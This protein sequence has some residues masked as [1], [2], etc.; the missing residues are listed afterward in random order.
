[1]FYDNDGYLPNFITAA[2]CWRSQQ[3]HILSTMLFI[4][5]EPHNFAGKTNW[6][7]HS[8]EFCRR[9]VIIFIPTP[10]P[11]VREI[12]AV[13]TQHPKVNIGLWDLI[14]AL[15]LYFCVTYLFYFSIVLLLL[16]NLLIINQCTNNIR[17]NE[18]SLDEQ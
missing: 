6:R 5:R 2:A 3:L 4:Q 7:W 13:K 10:S 17:P 14:V 16:A 9:F 1:V 15:K 8:T 12:S 18:R 11:L